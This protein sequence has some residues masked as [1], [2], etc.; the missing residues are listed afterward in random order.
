[1][2]LTS[3]IV[4]R[5]RPVLTVLGLVF[6][7][8]QL[9]PYGWTHSNPPIT[10]PVRWDSPQVESVVRAACYDCH[11]NET[12]WPV[13]AYVAPMSWLV[14]SD[15]ESGR[16]ELNFSEWDDFDSEADDAAEEVIVG[17]MPPR[18]Y[19]LLHPDA[20][21]NNVEKRLLIDAFAQLDERD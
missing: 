6:L 14:R 4:R 20:Q 15:V 12:D 3:R 10:D 16:D 19:T 7:A 8:I 1:M 5:L 2:V 11:S 17:S 21:L 18:E 13:Y 9:V